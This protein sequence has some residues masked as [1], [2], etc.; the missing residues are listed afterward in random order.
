MAAHISSVM[1]VQNDCM[2]WDA[3]PRAHAVRLVLDRN[4]YDE[5]KGSP[6][7]DVDASRPTTIRQ[8]TAS[9]STRDWSGKLETLGLF[10]ATLAP[11]LSTSPSQPRHLSRRLA[12]A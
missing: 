10:R 3:Q 1:S 5:A 11:V 12:H 4:A 9:E 6:H 7:N 2:K 8:F